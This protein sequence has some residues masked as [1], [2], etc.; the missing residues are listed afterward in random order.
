VVGILAVLSLAL[1]SVYF[2]ESDDGVLHGAQDVGATLVRPFQVG[3]ER[4]ARPF[5]DLYGWF[6]GLVTAKEEN[7]KLRAQLELAQ[8]QAIENQT[9]AEEV[10]ALKEA[11]DHQDLPGLDAYRP[12][13]TRVLAESTP[14][15]GQRLVIAAGSDAGITMHAPVLA[16]GTLVG[17]V[18]AVT[19]GTALV[20][21]I[22]DEASAVGAYVIRTNATGLVEAGEGGTLALNNVG[23]EKDV[24]VDDI[25]ATAGSPTSDLPSL[26]PRGIPIGT[27]TSVSQTDTEPYKL[28]Q[29]ESN[30][31]LSNLYVVTVLV[32]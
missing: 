11:L 24:K 18:T 6:D 15:F 29:V 1:L 5:R 27:V 30:V 16:A 26:Y 10:R 25:V 2:R 3:A 19:T 28:V 22:T 13:N 12:V 4:L 7:E 20:T 21:L 8:R 32:R 17:R 14:Q 31:D 23:K 9:A